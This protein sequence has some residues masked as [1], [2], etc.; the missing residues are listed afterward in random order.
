MP[1]YLNEASLLVCSTCEPICWAQ[2]LLLN[3]SYPFPSRTRADVVATRLFHTCW[4]PNT[5]SSACR[6]CG[7]PPRETCTIMT[8]MIATIFLR[9][10]KRW[11]AQLMKLLGCRV[12]ERESGVRFPV[13]TKDHSLHRNSRPSLGPVSP[14]VEQLVCEADHPLPFSA[15]VKN[16]AAI[17]QL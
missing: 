14:G 8:L 4:K 3:L 11:I 9:N 2:L 17:P 6:Q 13:W 10:V 5:G 1:F 15:E 7:H 16:D 12:D